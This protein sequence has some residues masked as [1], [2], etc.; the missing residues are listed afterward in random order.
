MSPLS[1]LHVTSLTG[2]L[3][4]V[5]AVA[6]ATVLHPDPRPDLTTL[7]RVLVTGLGGAAFFASAI[8]V[9]ELGASSLRVEALATSHLGRSAAVVVGTAA[10]L[11]VGA[12][13]S[14][15]WTAAS[16]QRAAMWALTAGM[17]L[18]S[19]A[20]WSH[21]STLGLLVR[22]TAVIGLGAWLGGGVTVALVLRQRDRDVRDSD[23]LWIR[24]RTVLAAGMIATVLMV[25]LMLA[26][27]ILLAGFAY[28]R[29]VDTWEAL[30]LLVAAAG[31][32][33]LLIVWAR[34]DRAQ[35]LDREL[36][37]E[38]IDEYDISIPLSRAWALTVL[39]LLGTLAGAQLL[40]DGA[41]G[42]ATA[43]GVSEAVIGLTIVAIGTSLPEL[44]TAVAAARH[45]E[46]DLIVG[47]VV[48]SN[49][50]NSLPVAGVAGVLDT[51]QLSAQFPTSLVLMGIVA[52]LFAVFA[53]QG[54]TIRRSEGL[55]LL[56]AFGGATLLTV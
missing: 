18:A 52:L 15:R 45:G 25:P 51:T 54:F 37:T 39:G 12:L 43:L 19:A 20:L 46:K 50:F 40:V 23:D 31:A 7:R 8:A 17:A 3:L 44:V 26:S 21:Q 47:N 55:V 48:G 13:H 30:V 5:G 6:V 10:L 36:E 22:G 16:P 28:D 38:V 4:A 1:L 9:Q 42:L 29:R 56:A 34:M 32:I 49:I 14:D 35:R 41:S 2:A 33:S 24:L 11:V 53:R 27:L